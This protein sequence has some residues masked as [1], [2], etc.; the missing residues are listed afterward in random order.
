MGA[1][2]KVSK[3][4]ARRESSVA[5]QGCNRRP[6]RLLPISAE[7]ALLKMSDFYKK[8]QIFECFCKNRH[9]KRE[10]P[11]GEKSLLKKG[12]TRANLF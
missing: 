10:H 5:T 1:S 6:T 2:A 9:K 3:E 8:V 11:A 4:E 12:R 7:G